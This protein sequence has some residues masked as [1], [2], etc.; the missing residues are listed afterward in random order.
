MTAAARATRYGLLALII[1]LG[2]ARS[3]A[4]FQLGADDDDAGAGQTLTVRDETV[5][6][7]F[8]FQDSGYND[9]VGWDGA[10]PAFTCYDVDPG[11][12]TLVGAFKGQRE[13]ILTLTTPDGHVWS[14]GPGTRNADDVA[15]A[16]LIQTAPDTVLVR[17]EDLPGDGDRDFNDC[18]YELHFTRGS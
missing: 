17:W 15:H 8:I 2:A 14:S 13:V 12:T 6:A 10:G 7:V 18:I 3:A 1:A 16:R 9:A 5:E 4:A 11:F